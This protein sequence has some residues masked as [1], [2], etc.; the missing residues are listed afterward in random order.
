MQA[1]DDTKKS[2][3]SKADEPEL[4]QTQVG[5]EWMN[6]WKKKEVEIVAGRIK[7]SVE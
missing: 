7:E 1:V 3:R 5:R 4:K 6:E 2:K